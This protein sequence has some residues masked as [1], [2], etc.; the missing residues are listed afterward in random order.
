MKKLLS[1]L[2]ILMMCM[3]LVSCK[4]EEKDEIG[5]II[6]SLTLP[7]KAA[8]LLIPSL[9]Y[10]RYVSEDNYDPLLQIGE[11]EIELLSSTGFGGIILFSENISSPEQT[12][13]LTEDLI[14]IN[15]ENGHLPL[16]ICA[17]QEGGG[18]RRIPFG[19]YMC[20]NMALAATDDLKD[21]SAY[22]SLIG[23]ELQDLHIN[24]SFAPVVDLNSN[25]YNPV[26]GVR[27]FSDDP[28]KIKN[29]VPSY[30]EALHQEGVISC[31]KHFP[32]H[33]ETD[34]DSHSSLPAVHKTLDELREY[35]LL[36][37]Q[38]GIDAGCDMIMTAHIQFPE[39]EKESHRGICLPATLSRTLITDVLRNELGFD[40]VVVTDALSMDAIAK[41][42]RKKEMLAYAINA[43]A[44]ML[45]VPVN[46][47]KSVSWYYMELRNTVTAICDLVEEGI[48]SQERIDESLR[49]ILMLKTERGLFDQKENNDS[50][51]VGSAQHHQTEMQIA[52]D[53]ITLIKND[54]ALPVK[55]NEK[56]LV[57]VPYA[58]QNRSVSYAKTLLFNE[59]LLNKKNDLSIYTYGSDTN[60]KDF[61]DHIKPLFK[62]IDKLILVSACYEEADL[63]G[64]QADIADL[65]LDHCKAKGIK[66]ILLSSQLPYDLPR[67]D[68]DALLACYY[69]AGLSSAIDTAHPTDQSFPP[70]LVAAMY[71][72]YGQQAPKGKLPI[73]VPELIKKDGRYTFGEQTAFERNTS[74]T[75]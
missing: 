33:G 57:L 23:D 30:I 4:S 56:T 27:S 60:K 34:T 69:A 59:G 54:G 73:D 7:Q 52:K 35:E 39:I 22:A 43:G 11:K 16:L 14:R 24:V 51:D 42:F 64:S 70:N 61:N 65:C 63:N 75:Y 29:Y 46:E 19:S 2:L 44:D 20:G 66:T 28:N 5:Q 67:Y 50:F 3:A 9:R 17:D 62:N 41:F 25:P 47:K 71:V 10:S 48:V 13:K 40:K 58:S 18:V 38:A 26:I 68:A 45:L 12:L 21:V 6:D 32:G 49:R 36:P 53:A 74:L 72:I 8:Q 1:F 37:F 31:L 55:K 15:K